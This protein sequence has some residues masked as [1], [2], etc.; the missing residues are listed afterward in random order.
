MYKISFNHSIRH[1]TPNDGVKH[2]LFQD[3][4]PLSV[5]EMLRRSQLGIP[6]SVAKPVENLPLNGNFFSDKFDV[7][8]TAIR[9][10]MRLSAEQKLNELE[11]QKQARKEI[12][13]FKAWKKE[14][15]ETMRN[16]K[17]VA[18]VKNE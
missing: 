17:Q 16:V 13:E 4:R 15:L 18:E 8:D 10:D 6:L 11:R 14:Q 7:I 12:E 1:I 5:K 2:P 9:N 3:E